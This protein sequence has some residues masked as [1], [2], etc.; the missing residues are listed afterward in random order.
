M[1][2]AQV[3]VLSSPIGVSNGDPA[4]W[5]SSIPLPDLVLGHF[6]ALAPVLRGVGFRDPFPAAILPPR[7]GLELWLIVLESCASEY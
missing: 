1:K 7:Y 6:H 2:S 5:R 3:R 4:L